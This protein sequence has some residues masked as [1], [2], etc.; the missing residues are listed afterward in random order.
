MNIERKFK[1]FSTKE[2]IQYL[3]Y[4]LSPDRE[5]E[6]EVEMTKNP[7]LNEA[8]K[9]IGDKENR[10]LSHQSISLL[11]GEVQQYTG[12]SESR[13]VQSKENRVLEPSVPMNWKLIGF[14]VGA[15]L[16]LGLLGYGIYYFLR[17]S[18]NSVDQEQTMVEAETVS[19]IQSYADSSSLPMETIPNA[20]TAASI[21][22]DSVA[23]ATVKKP[24]A[25]PKPSQSSTS[26]GS[27]SDQSSSSTPA[28][29]PIS[30]I[31]PAASQKERELFN[32]AQESF[33]QGNREEAKKIL[34][35]LKSYD[36]PMKSQAETILKNIEN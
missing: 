16:L 18:A 19:N 32:Q 31:N 4:K 27:S 10:A 34:R 11:I 5:K 28:V 14:I 33:K 6:L 13:I 25:K 24:A 35:E 8:V 26:D 17:N 22:I 29:K 21:P 2:W 36:N 30:S 12:V 1:M 3:Q 23:S 20:T 9:V 7:F 15:L